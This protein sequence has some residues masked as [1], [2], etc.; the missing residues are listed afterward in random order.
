[1]TETRGVLKD[2]VLIK[3]SNCCDPLIVNSGF[4]KIS[5][6]QNFRIFRISRISG[7]QDFRISG[8]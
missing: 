5:G 2:L 8:F 6:F 7:F 4:S 3:N 1:M